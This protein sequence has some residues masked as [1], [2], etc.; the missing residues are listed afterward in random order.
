MT[1][2]AVSEWQDEER[3]R[4]L[5]EGVKDYAIF[6]LDTTGHVLTWN[7]GAQRIKG[8]SADEII[9]KH[10]STF[11]P[12]PEADSDRCA[13]ELIEA[14]RTGRFEEEGWRVRKDGTRFWAS[15]VITALHGPDGKL[16]GFA[17]VTRDLTE[18]TQAEEKLRQSE[19]RV[20]LL[21]DSIKDYA[22]FMLD[23]DGKVATWNPGAERINL[24]RASEIIGQH[25]STFYLEEDVKRGKC[26]QDLLIAAA[27]GRF[28]EEGWR[29]RKDGSRFW[30]GVTISAIR[31][32]RGQLLG[33]GKVTRDLSERR[34]AEEK[35]RQS[36]LKL[37]QLVD[38]IKDYAVFM[39]DPQGYVSTWNSGA[40]SIS[41]Y[42]ADEILGKHFSTFYPPEVIQSG[43]CDAELAIAT[44]TG[45]FEEEGWR[46]RK[47]GTH[48]WASVV[49]NAV[50][51]DN[52]YLLGFSKVTRDLSERKRM[53]EERTARLAAEEASRAKDEFLAILGHELRNPLAPMVTALQLIR[54][55]AEQLGAREVAVIDRQ[56]KHM[57]RLVEDLLDVARLA[58]GKIELR[59][60]TL[61]LREVVR[62]ALEV[63]SP[64]LEQRR[65]HFELGEAATE[66]RVS[67]DEARLVQVF[68]NLLTNAAKYT[69]PGGHIG[70]VVRQ[71][72]EQAVVEVSDD[73]KGIAPDLLARVFELFV[74]G[75]QGSER[76]GGGL[77]IGLTLV[78]QL[79][80]A[81]GGTVEA[82]SAGL[83]QGSTFTV[84]L[85]VA[86]PAPAAEVLRPPSASGLRH[87]ARPCRVLFV[88]DNDDAREL[89]ALV[90]RR[91]GHEVVT[92]A[93][94]AEALAAVQSFLPD[95]GVLDIGLPVIDGYELAVRLRAVLGE[96]CPRLIALTGYGQA[97]DRERSVRAG[98]DRHMVKPIEASELLDCIDEVRAM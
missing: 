60:Q 94:G 15:V 39:L 66:I 13:G 36:E 17:K 98:F 22:I 58:R 34:R 55:R 28:E 2:A 97:H 74:Q 30:A 53:L 27:T 69:E 24:Y 57:V 78:R 67:I 62:R 83:G 29:V 84:R 40:E 61:D 25:M 31:D 87:A 75:H 72:G 12:D 92:A 46:L 85:P 71:E 48:Y 38:S 81:H 95:V 9:G 33:Y 16:E 51:N 14:V 37:R 1:S 4:L 43:Q 8:Y 10:F 90:L 70:M 5:V 41:G 63:A 50:R 52:G 32:E 56:V 7:L 44:T 65:H 35:L 54:P 91:S 93:D 80:L 77:G 23:P 6:M 89:G 20:R 82:R 76:S 47:D 18:R 19:Q 21:V 86:V 42:S 26:E 11:Y 45:R 59:L 64:L 88:D 49:I 73:G 3:F 79:V 96:R 68:T